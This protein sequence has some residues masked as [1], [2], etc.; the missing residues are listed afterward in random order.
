VDGRQAAPDRAEPRASSADRSSR[1]EP[2]RADAGTASAGTPPA[3][4][5]PRDPFA[6]IQRPPD[7]AFKSRTGE[8][9]F[10]FL[11]YVETLEELRRTGKLTEQQ[12]KDEIYR[13]D[14]TVAGR[15]VRI[16]GRMY[17]FR[18]YPKPSA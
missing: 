16:K 12:F 18:T 8:S 1:V 17:D 3:P 7:G 4:S 13:V 15:T 9:D 2:G 5:A 10:G 6:G 14:P 11:D